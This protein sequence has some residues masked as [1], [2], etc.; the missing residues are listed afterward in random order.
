MTSPLPSQPTISEDP[1]SSR[2]YTQQLLC[3]MQQVGL[4]SYATLYRKTGISRRQILRLRRGE[5]QQLQVETLLKLS[6]VMQ[7]SLPDLLTL[8]S[9]QSVAAQSNHQTDQPDKA[10][11][12]RS[13]EQSLTAADP[14]PLAL[15][16]EYQ[17]LQEQLLQQRQS[18]WEEFQQTTLQ[19]LESF[20]LQWPTAAYAAQNNPQA[21]AIRLLPLLRPVEQ[22]LASWNVQPI[23]AV[24]IEVPYDPQLHQ[25]E[26]TAP[27]DNSLTLTVGMPV[28]IR[29]VG[30][31]QGDR[32][33][34]R[35]RVSKGPKTD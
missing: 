17:R 22:L 19:T 28:K 34:Y 31:R 26:P 24:G 25:L 35:A 10:V 33:L 16:L 29:Y 2:D 30:Y 15:K 6:Q 11:L 20:L 9:N 4:S 12:T 18:L 3:L 1:S 7:V 21:P 23:G 13:Q 27:S 8:F 5:I 32:L 14:D